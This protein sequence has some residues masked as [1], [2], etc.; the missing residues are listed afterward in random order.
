MKVSRKKL[1]NGYQELY[2]FPNGY[3]ASV[4]NHTYSYGLELAVIY[5][6]GEEFDLVYDTPITDDVIG[7]LTNERVEELLLKIENLPGRKCH[8]IFY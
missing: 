7:H 3:G 8:D 5:W 6:R 1:F 2:E 4:I